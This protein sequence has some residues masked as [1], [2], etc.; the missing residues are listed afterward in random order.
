[1]DRAQVE[2]LAESLGGACAKLAKGSGPVS[3]VRE[4]DAEV[5]LSEVD[6]RLAQ[7]LAGLGPFGQ[8]NAA[9]VL[10]TRGAPLVTAGPTGRR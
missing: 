10:V 3:A 2:A 9:P 4:I 1:M 5:R 6:E 8:E 7:E